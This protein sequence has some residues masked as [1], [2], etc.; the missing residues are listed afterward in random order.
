MFHD[1]QTFGPELEV[2]LA[3]A[4]G[5]DRP[6]LASFL[7]F[8]HALARAL[9]VASEPIVGQLRL[10][11]WR[12]ALIAEPAVRSQGNPQL[13]ELSAHFGRHLGH[14]VSMVDGWEALLLAEPLD[15]V[16]IE[17]FAT[18]RAEGWQVIANALGCE[19]DGTAVYQ[20]G[21]LWAL[22]DLASKLDDP[23]ERDL[24]LGYANDLGT[25]LA[26]FSRRLRP[27]AVLAVLSQRSIKE[28]GT[29]LMSGRR[30]A[31]TALRVGLFGM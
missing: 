17:A 4:T 28:R 2:A 3:Y 20:A 10:A 21:R 8:D 16:A 30:S 9:A 5:R 23:G 13:T 11:W 22:A 31:L 15:V 25:G 1:A 19:D 27:L 6:L 12:D 29:A 26:R 18:G 14:L 7:G 24:V